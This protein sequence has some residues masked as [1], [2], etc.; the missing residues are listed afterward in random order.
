MRASPAADGGAEVLLSAARSRWK[1]K[2]STSIS[3]LLAAFSTDPLPAAVNRRKQNFAAALSSLALEAAQAAARD[4][5]GSADRH[6]PPSAVEE[7]QLS[8]TQRR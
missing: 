7:N 4:R 5:P 2:A 3:P 1:S 8:P 6:L